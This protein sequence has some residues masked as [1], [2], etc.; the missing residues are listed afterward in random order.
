MGYWPYVPLFGS[1]AELGNR[2]MGV[3]EW[4]EASVPGGVHL[5]LLKAGIIEDP[6]YE[7]NSLKC[8]W[9]ENRWWVYRTAFRLP[10]QF[11]GKNLRLLFKGLDY[12]AYIYLNGSKLGEHEGM[13]EPAVFDVTQSAK[14]RDE[15]VVEVLFEHAPD[16]MSQIGMTSKVRTVKSRFAYKWD[17]CTR[18]VNIGFWDDVVV[19]ATGAFSVDEPFLRSWWKGTTGRI[20][21]GFFAEGKPQAS[22]NLGVKIL[23]GEEIV[24]EHSEK[25][26]L[27]SKRQ[28]YDIAAEIPDP[29]LWHPNGLG[30][31]HLYRVVLELHDADGVSDKREFY[32]GIRNLRYSRNPQSPE[33][34]LPYTVIVNGKPVYI[35]GV[36]LAPFDQ[37]Y[38]GVSPETYERYVLLL[39]KG[40]INM[41]RVNGVGV[42]EKEIFYH[43]CDVHGIMIWQDFIQSS[44]GIDNI[45]PEDPHV[46]E[47]LERSA[48][49]AVKEK[50]NHVSHTIWCG[51]NE[52]MDENQIPVTCANNNISRLKKVVEELDPFLTGNHLSL[53][54]PWLLLK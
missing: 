13:F 38:G 3:T 12:K 7:L 20:T 48:Q 51:G 34:S 39:K 46:L 9:V 41:V 33:D 11:I 49:H 25:L 14:A 24:F 43:L 50:R 16:E 44:S 45:P 28:R 18:L 6:Y 2:L 21:L 17:W 23:D 37:L 36:N 22:G 15:N 53:L 5:D 47:L 8:E 31:Q 42:T 27:K 52:L 10:D 30:P 1:G 4:L 32:T 54:D 19:L 35:K 26:T 29:K 40:N